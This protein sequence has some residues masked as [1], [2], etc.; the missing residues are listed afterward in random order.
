MKL[1]ETDGGLNGILARFMLATYAYLYARTSCKAFVP[2]N[3]KVERNNVEPRI[4][5]K[6]INL[7]LMISYGK[8]FGLENLAIFRRKRR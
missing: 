8:I 4:F 7:I 2:E 3:G 6:R 1:R 5:S